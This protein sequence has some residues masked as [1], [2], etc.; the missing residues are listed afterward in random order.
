M[1]WVWLNAPFRLQCCGCGRRAKRRLKGDVCR[2]VHVMTTI[3]FVSALFAFSS[4]RLTLARE[5]SKID[6][7]IDRSQIVFD[8]HKP[9]ISLDA[10]GPTTVQA[11]KAEKAELDWQELTLDWQK[12]QLGPGYTDVIDCGW[13]DIGILNTGDVVRME[14]DGFNA[15]NSEIAGWGWYINVWSGDARHWTTSSDAFRLLH[16]NPR[17][18]GMIVAMNHFLQGGWGT[19]KDAGLP[20]VW[21]LENAA[22]PFILEFEL[23]FD[24]W[25]ISLN[26]ERQPELTYPRKGDF[27][28]PLTFQVYDIINPYM[29]IK[30]KAA[31]TTFAPRDAGGPNWQQL[32]LDWKKTQLG[33]GY[34]DKIDSAWTDLGVLQTGTILRISADGYNKKDS[35]IAGWGWYLNVWSGDARHWT[36]SQ[37]ASRLLHF[38]P[39][40]RAFIVAINN[41]IRGAWGAEKDAGLPKPWLLENAGNPFE[42][43]MELFAKSWSIR[44]NGEIQP[45]MAYPRHG[46]FSK[47]LTLQLYD[48][49]NPRVAIKR[50]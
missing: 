44:I 22:K 23:G 10:L 50:A 5:H 19:E 35:K 33:P 31:T 16:F 25:K 42:L 8:S 29:K 1:M 36:S 43:E 20:E 11:H 17:P 45:E 26:D 48:I 37:D 24:S 7:K 38:N 30:K 4:W 28:Q 41:C 34:P 13:T 2:N 46:D 39:R 14:A 49:I 12:T 40:P 18:R 47:R 3:A 32:K 15:E 21:L 27:T 9:N 6:R